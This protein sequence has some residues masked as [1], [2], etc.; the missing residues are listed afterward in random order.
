MPDVLVEVSGIPTSTPPISSASIPTPVV[1]VFQP[2]PHISSFEDL[3]IPVSIPVNPSTSKTAYVGVTSTGLSIH[4]LTR[5]GSS[6]KPESLFDGDFVLKTNYAES[7]DLACIY[8]LVDCSEYKMKIIPCVISISNYFIPVHVA[9]FLNRLHFPL[10]PAF[11]DFLI[12]IQSQP[13]H[14]YLNAVRYIM[15]LIVLCR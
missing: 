4:D 7:L 2:S 8:S 1:F 15:S 5:V 11:V 3:T 14:V 9:H 12:L 13:T 6:S 10:D